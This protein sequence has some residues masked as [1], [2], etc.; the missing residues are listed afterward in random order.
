MIDPALV[1][2][3]RRRDPG[4]FDALHARCA[5]MVHAIGL[6]HGVDADDLVQDVFLTAWQRIGDLRDDASFAPW[7]G[8]IARHRAR[9][10]LRRPRL[11]EPLPDSGAQPPPALEA[12]EALRH[13]R[14]LPEA[15]RETLTMR[16]VEGLTGP[17]IAALTGLTPDSVRVNLHRGMALLRASLKGEP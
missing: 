13:L 5:R 17:E 14:A 10:V 8:T 1:A 11:V 4:A 3:A 2:R 7:L 6:A 9:D 15:Y 16:L 12:A